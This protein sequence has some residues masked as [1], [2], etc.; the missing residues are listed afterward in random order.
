VIGVRRFLHHKISGAT[1]SCN[2][3]ECQGGVFEIATAGKPDC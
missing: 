2:S 3:P 1:F